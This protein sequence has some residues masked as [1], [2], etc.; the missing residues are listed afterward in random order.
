[1]KR[2]LQ[3]ILVAGEEQRDAV[4]DGRKRITVREGHRD[5]ITGPVL[6]GCHILGWATMR[7]IIKVTHKLLKEVT[8]AECKA[9]GFVNMADMLHGLREYYPTISPDSEVTVIEWD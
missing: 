3:A 4:F 5:Y 9:D 8:E 2:V 6:I 7:N 1:M